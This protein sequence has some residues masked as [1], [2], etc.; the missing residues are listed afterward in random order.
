M[1]IT[2]DNLLSFQFTPEQLPAIFNIIERLE[3]LE[4][5]GSARFKKPTLMEVQ[6]D[7]SE[8]GCQNYI[9]EAQSFI[10]YFE[11]VGWVVG[12]TRKPMKAWKSAVNNWLKNNYSKPAPEVK[13]AKVAAMRNIHDTSW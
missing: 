12:K 5:K 7:M 8:K 1:K 4:S 10:D 2:E 13:Q 11:Q 6:Q 9:S 3:A